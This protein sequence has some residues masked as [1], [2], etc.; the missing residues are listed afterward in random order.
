MTGGVRR[1]E[2]ALCDIHLE[3]VCVIHLEVVWGIHL[4]AA[5]CFLRGE[6]PEIRLL[7]LCA[8]FALVLDLLPQLALDVRQL[9]LGGAL[10]DLEQFEVCAGAAAVSDSHHI[11]KPLRLI[12]LAHIG[13]AKVDRALQVRVLAGA[14][15]PRR[16]GRCGG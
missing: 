10:A 1:N 13:A 7:F 4:E 8:V 6:A 9:L 5:V 12:A 16:G 11:V 2:R 15:L 14:D 3:A